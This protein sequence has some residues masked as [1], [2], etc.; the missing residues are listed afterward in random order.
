MLSPC[1]TTS[2]SRRK[3]PFIRHHDYLSPFAGYLIY[4]YVSAMS[5]LVKARQKFVGINH[6]RSNAA[7]GTRQ[8]LYSNASDFKFSRF[9]M[10]SGKENVQ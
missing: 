6:L 7:T 4:A 1:C 10:Y 8:E 2:Y 3:R 5:I 9:C